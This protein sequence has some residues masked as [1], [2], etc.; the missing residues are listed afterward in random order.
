M[1][2]QLKLSSMEPLIH[3]SKEAHALSLRQGFELESQDRTKRLALE[4]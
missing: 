4:G 3:H 1:P 2:L